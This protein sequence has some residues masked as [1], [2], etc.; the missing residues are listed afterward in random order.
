[1]QY[2]ISASVYSEVL[3]PI[4]AGQVVC[5][6]RSPDS[7]VC[8]QVRYFPSA[9]PWN[10]SGCLSSTRKNTHIQ[11]RYRALGAQRPLRVPC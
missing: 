1:M 7:C 3:K 5:W 10:H 4:L 8:G 2:S 11:W 9:L 6:S